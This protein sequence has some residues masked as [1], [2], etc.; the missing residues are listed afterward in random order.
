MNPTLLVTSIPP[1]ISFNCI[2]E[3]KYQWTKLCITSWFQTG[4][5]VISVNTEKEIIQLKKFYP[6]INFVC[7]EKSTLQI[8]NRPLIFIFDALQKASFFN[9]ERYAICNADILISTNITELQLEK[10][11]CAYSNRIDIEKI[12]SIN[13]TAFGGI[14]YF[15]LSHYFFNCLPTNYFAFGLP[16]WDYWLPYY[17]LSNNFKLLKLVDKGKSPILLH[18]KHAEAWKPDDLCNMGKHFFDLIHYE[19]SIFHENNDFISAY[20]NQPPANEKKAFYYALLARETC[21]YIHSQAIEY[22]VITD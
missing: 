19:N 16:W 5:E 6:N 21:A 15:N 4:H 17:A 13:G 9:Y 7:T 3:S 12:D 11:I 14:D 18:K 10:N 20:L 1:P 2:D 8:N 22:R